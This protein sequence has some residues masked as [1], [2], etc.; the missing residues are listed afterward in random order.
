MSV[1]SPAR[2]LLAKREM[3]GTGKATVKVWC[4]P[5]A[6]RRLATPAT[7]TNADGDPV[8]AFCVHLED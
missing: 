3:T 1:V 4:V 6:R 5:C 2:T 7:L 8:C